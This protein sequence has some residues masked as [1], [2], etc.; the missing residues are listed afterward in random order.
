MFT[1]GGDCVV[2][3]EG[4]CVITWGGD[5]VITWGGDCVHLGRRLCDHLGRRLC[6]LG[7]ETMCSLGEETMHVFF[8]P[9]SIISNRL[10]VMLIQTFI[11]QKLKMTL[12]IRTKQSNLFKLQF[13]LEHS[14][15]WTCLYSHVNVHMHID[16]SKAISS[17]D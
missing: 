4:D 10:Q 1:W 5:C 3:W 15:R 13:N 17:H 9:H 11:K 12:L 16:P 6:S 8:S 14:L 2:T 7:E